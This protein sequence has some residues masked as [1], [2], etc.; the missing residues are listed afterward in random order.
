MKTFGWKSHRVAQGYTKVDAATVRDSYIR[1]MESLDAC[2]DVRPQS[3]SIEAYFVS[4]GAP[5]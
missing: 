1:A 5:K 4:Q 3:Q 2:K